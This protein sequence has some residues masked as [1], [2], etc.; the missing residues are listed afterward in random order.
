MRRIWALLP[1]A[2]AIGCVDADMGIA[3]DR[4]EPDVVGRDEDV[5]VVLEG[6][7]PGD[8]YVS[9]DDGSVSE[10]AGWIVRIGDREIAEPDVERLDAGRLLVYL[11]SGL[12]RGHHD[13]TVEAPSGESATAPGAL[14]VREGRYGHGAGEGSGGNP[15]SAAVP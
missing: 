7:F 14:R 9:L 8:V 1:C 15:I 12:P 4:V 5:E 3:I 6:R 13:V 2:F 11:A 10:D